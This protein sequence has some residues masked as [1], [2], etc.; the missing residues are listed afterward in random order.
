[1]ATA[2]FA[3]A[4]HA[5]RVWGDVVMRHTGPGVAILCKDQAAAGTD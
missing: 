1:M 5:K 4:D 3:H 2:P